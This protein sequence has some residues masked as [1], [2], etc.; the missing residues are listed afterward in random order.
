MT[1]LLQ[2]LK[3]FVAE[4]LLKADEE[5]CN[6]VAFPA[7]GTGNLRYP[8]R[9]VAEAMLDGVENYID[10]TMSGTLKTV[11]ITTT[12]DQMHQVLYLYILLHMFSYMFYIFTTATCLYPVVV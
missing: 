12:D 3:Q 11:Y 2:V 9:N 10:E 5:N 4:C 6:S 1:L 7:L 8:P